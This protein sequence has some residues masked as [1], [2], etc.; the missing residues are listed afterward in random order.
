MHAVRADP[1]IVVGGEVG[2]KTDVFAPK[3]RDEEGAA[4]GFA[5]VEIWLARESRARSVEVFRRA[6]VD[7]R[8]V[9]ALSEEAGRAVGDQR[10]RARFIGDRLIDVE[11]I[12]VFAFHVE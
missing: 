4:A 2:E 7:V 11:L 6:E 8:E 12:E 5:Q 1:G 9:F 3:R 10:R